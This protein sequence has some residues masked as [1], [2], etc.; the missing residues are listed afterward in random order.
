VSNMCDMQ[1]RRR[2][3]F[4]T[5]FRLQRKRESPKRLARISAADATLTSKRL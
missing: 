2:R 1:V 3:S 4:R 5:Y